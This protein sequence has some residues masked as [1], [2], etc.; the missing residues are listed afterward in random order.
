[1]VWS[2]I[3]LGGS[4]ARVLV[5]N[6]YI[7]PLKVEL[8]SLYNFSFWCTL[9]FVY[10]FSSRPMSRFPSIRHMTGKGLDICIWH[11]FVVVVTLQLL[12]W[13][14]SP[15]EISHVSV[16]MT[17]YSLNVY[18]LSLSY[19]MQVSSCST[20]FPRC[21]MCANANSTRKKRATG[22]GRNVSRGGR[23]TPWRHGALRCL[24]PIELLL[25]STCSSLLPVTKLLILKLSKR[26]W[27]L[28]LRWLSPKT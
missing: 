22:K 17:C 12:S 4:Q 3:V 23:R 7:S 26:A 1:M 21:R 16:T 13:S 25:L 8:C 24:F 18:W 6:V 2:N 5:K 15:S 11:K 28:S 9:S 20:R 14:F 10:C 27:Y 19:P